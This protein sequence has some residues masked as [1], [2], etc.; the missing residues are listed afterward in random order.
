LRRGLLSVGVARGPIIRR[1]V[2]DAPRP[3]RSYRLGLELTP[4]FSI[5]RSRD[6]VRVRFPTREVVQLARVGKFQTLLEKK[7]G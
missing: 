2:R 7:K 6:R 4:D 3:E 1:Q 5:C